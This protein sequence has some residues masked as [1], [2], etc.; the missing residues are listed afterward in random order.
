MRAAPHHDD[1]PA[2]ET[3]AFIVP[4]GCRRFGEPSTYSLTAVELAQHIRWLRC[5]GW[6]AWEVRARFGWRWAA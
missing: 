5:Q 1:A 4:Q 6:Q 2:K 3:V